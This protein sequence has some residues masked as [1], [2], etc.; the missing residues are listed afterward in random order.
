MDCKYSTCRKKHDFRSKVNLLSCFF[1]EIGLKCARASTNVELFEI[2]KVLS[3]LDLL[4]RTIIFPVITQPRFI[5]T[6]LTVSKQHQDSQI[7]SSLPAWVFLDG[8]AVSSGGKHF[9]AANGHQLTALVSASHVI[10][11]RSI[12]DEGVQFA[13]EYGTQQVC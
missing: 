10:Q 1:G 7:H 8:D 5:S 6:K 12:I 2:Q 11:H 4:T 13:V 3:D 9:A